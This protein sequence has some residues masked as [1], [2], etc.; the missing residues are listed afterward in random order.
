MNAL[1][2]SLIALSV[3]MLATGCAQISESTGASQASVGAA[4]GAAGGAVAGSV[5]GRTLKLDRT[6]T[7]AIGGVVG[8][9]IGYNVGRAEDL[10]AAEAARA[11]IE[12]RGF[13]ATIEMEPAP[14][15]NAMQ[16]PVG[17]QQQPQQ[18][19][20]KSLAAPIPAVA[21]RTQ[22]PE[23][24]DTLRDLGSVAAANS[25]PTTV[26]VTAPDKKAAEWSKQQVLAGAAGKPTVRVV[27]SVGKESGVAMMPDYTA[28]A[29]AR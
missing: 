15:Q 18:Q 29:S 5:L 13:K 12:Q 6:T 27:A 24:R 1:K 8:G 17:A 25:A 10:K 23:A 16:V 28:V 26:Y 22:A 3:A 19:T 14:V 4:V 7:A 20:L 2:N 11:R 9:V 21:L